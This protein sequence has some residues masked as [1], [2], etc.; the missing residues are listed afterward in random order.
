MPWNRT[1]DLWLTILLFFVI[2]KRDIASG[3]YWCVY[4]MVPRKHLKIEGV[5]YFCIRRSDKTHLMKASTFVAFVLPATHFFLS[6]NWH[7]VAA[8]LCWLKSTSCGFGGAGTCVADFFVQ[9]SPVG[10]CLHRVSQSPW[11]SQW[12]LTTPA[13]QEK[14]TRVTWLVPK[15]LFFLFHRTPFTKVAST[16]AIR[17]LPGT[18]TRASST[19]ATPRHNRSRR[20]RRRSRD[21]RS[22]R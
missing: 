16:R 9:I 22:R 1:V 5:W 10:C 18:A 7:N 21:S 19:R 17:P 11:R 13:Q 12:R 8:W 20:S 6:T 4:S 3:L 14:R 2:G 15:P